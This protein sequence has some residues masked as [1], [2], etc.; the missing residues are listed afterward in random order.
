MLLPAILRY[1]TTLFYSIRSHD[2]LM[3][4]SGILFSLA[5]NLRFRRMTYMHA[6]AH[7]KS[8]HMA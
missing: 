1:F 6:R 8:W 4:I 5:R 3:G 2:T 7:L